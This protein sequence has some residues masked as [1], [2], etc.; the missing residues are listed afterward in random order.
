MLVKLDVMGRMCAIRQLTVPKHKGQ[1]HK[2]TPHPSA[3]YDGLTAVEEGRDCLHVVR[4]NVSRLD[5]DGDK[6]LK[7]SELEHAHSPIC[8]YQLKHNRRNK[9]YIRADPQFIS[10]HACRLS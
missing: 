4:K 3:S 5:V 6:A 8:N 10:A 9:S 1:A 2:R 7:L